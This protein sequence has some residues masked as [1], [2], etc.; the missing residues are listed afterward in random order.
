MADED[1]RVTVLRLASEDILFV[2]IFG[3]QFL[4]A[5]GKISGWTCQ[6]SRAERVLCARIY[7]LHFA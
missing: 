3:W 5:D 6:V 7:A 1:S 2:K 4:L